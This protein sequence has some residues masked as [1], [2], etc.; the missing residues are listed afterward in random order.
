MAQQLSEQDHKLDADSDP[1][2]TRPDKIGAAL[3]EQG[4]A[5]VPMTTEQVNKFME[6][7]QKQLKE[8]FN[9]PPPPPFELPPEQIE[10]IAK[11][12]HALIPTPPLTAAK[13]AALTLLHAPAQSTSEVTV[14]LPAAAKLPA[15]PKDAP[16]LVQLLAN[17]LE[18]SLEL[19]VND[20]LLKD[21]QGFQDVIGSFTMSLLRGAMKEAAGD[22]A[23]LSK[24]Q[25]F[26]MYYNYER[27]FY[28]LVCERS[29]SA[30]A[31]FHKKT[32]SALARSKIEVA[33]IGEISSYIYQAT[34]QQFLPKHGSCPAHPGDAHTEA[35]C[36]LRVNDIGEF[37]KLVAKKMG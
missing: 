1:A 13:P 25:H 9:P 8:V 35:T 7:Q 33:S 5:K 26:E 31:H 30:A 22:Q 28:T 18:K 27:L 23:V 20:K 37:N 3:A 24:L 21:Q 4:G 19:K 11:A 14:P 15:A 29:W 34:C 6:F 2:L 12:L 10:A 17:Q 16:E 32:M 36:K